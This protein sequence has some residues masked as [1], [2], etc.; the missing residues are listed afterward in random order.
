MA[1]MLSRFFGE[2][3]LRLREQARALQ[4]WLKKK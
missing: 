2:V 3:E 4:E 1:A